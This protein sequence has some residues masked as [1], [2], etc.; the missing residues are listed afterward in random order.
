M[1][2]QGRGQWAVVAKTVVRGRGFR[3]FRVVSNRGWATVVVTEFLRLVKP[4]VVVSSSCQKTEL[5][6]RRHSLAAVVFHQVFFLELNKKEKEKKSGH[7]SDA[8][9]FA[10]TVPHCIQK[11]QKCHCCI[12]PSDL[13]NIET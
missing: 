8:H 7:T 12:T 4:K 11:K 5:T 13:D 10:R 6:M 3:P 1:F 9:L 2:E